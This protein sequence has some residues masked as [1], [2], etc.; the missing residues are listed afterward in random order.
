MTLHALRKQVG[1]VDFFR[2]LRTWATRKAG[3][4]GTTAQFVELA[5]SISRQQ[6][7]GLFQTWLFTPG[8][9]A[10]GL[11]VMAARSAAGASTQSPPPAVA[12]LMERLSKG[13][14]P[15]RR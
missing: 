3:G 12:S 4:N 13:A 2:I 10:L 15:R 9:P 5:E 7:E 11:A 6:L 1:D 14:E 8:K